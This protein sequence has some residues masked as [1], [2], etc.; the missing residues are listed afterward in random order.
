MKN[1]DFYQLCVDLSR[2][3]GEKDIF[4]LAEHGEILIQECRVG[5]YYNE[6]VDEV[7]SCFVDI[8]YLEDTLRPEIFETILSINLELSGINSESLGFDRDTGHLVLRADIACE[9]DASQIAE[10]L[11]DYLDFSKELQNLI[12][13]QSHGDEGLSEFFLGKAA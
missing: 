6:E 9:Y 8:G 5:L 7:I 12:A 10:F 3:F 13:S 2:E 11:S 4:H 1:E